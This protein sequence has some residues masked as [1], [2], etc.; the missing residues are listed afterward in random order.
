MAYSH[1]LDTLG[2]SHSLA[3]AC[4]AEADRMK[5]MLDDVEQTNKASWRFPTT[6]FEG[7]ARAQM[8]D[9]SPQAE[10]HMLPRG[11]HV[12]L[13]ARSVEAR[14]FV[15]KATDYSVRRDLLEIARTYDQIAKQTAPRLD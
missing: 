12:W 3:E 2:V 15:E 10:A 11:F 9:Q 14:S 6:P 4:Q 7:G 13:D 8:L 1:W 5:R